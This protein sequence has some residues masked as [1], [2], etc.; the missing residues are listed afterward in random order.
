V[1][2]WAWMQVGARCCGVHCAVLCHAMV[3]CPVLCCAG[4]S[5]QVHIC[6][7][8]SECVCEPPINPGD[9]SGK[10]SV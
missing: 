7:A 1:D 4:H 9:P 8:T 6:L 3:R 5:P 2:A 10:P